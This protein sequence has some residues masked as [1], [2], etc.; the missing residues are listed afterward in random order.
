MIHNGDWISTET[1]EMI[2][3]YLSKEESV[4]NPMPIYGYEK[5]NLDPSDFSFTV[6]PSKKQLKLLKKLEIDYHGDL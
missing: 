5:L 2:D 6:N 4:D 3:E 1:V